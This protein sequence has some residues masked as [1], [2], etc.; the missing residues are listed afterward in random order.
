M[1]IAPGGHGHT[2]ERGSCRTAIIA[3]QHPGL[4]ICA[5]LCPIAS[6]RGAAQGLK[7]QSAKEAASPDGLGRHHV[8]DEVLPSCIER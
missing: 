1:R 6:V 3:S 7:P 2:E 4:P 5:R 8:L